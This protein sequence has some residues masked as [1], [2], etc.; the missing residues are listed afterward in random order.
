NPAEAGNMREGK[1]NTSPDQTAVASP[2]SDLDLHLF[3]EGKHS[4]LYLKMG[5]QWTGKGT[6]FAVW[7]P[8]AR[9][10]SVLGDFNQWQGT[11]FR[12]SPRGHSGIWEGFISEAGPGQLYKYRIHSRH[13]NQVLDKADPF[14]GYAELA[15]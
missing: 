12:L 9:A 14:A 7:A 2:L 4:R 5:S 1:I 15:P 8:D 10:V 11:G 3:N 6:H 13:G